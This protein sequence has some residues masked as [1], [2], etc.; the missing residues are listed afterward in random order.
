MTGEPEKKFAAGMIRA[1][2]W[3]NTAKNGNEFKSVSVTKSYQKD[4]EWKNR[5]CKRRKL[6]LWAGLRKN[7]LFEF[8]YL[9]SE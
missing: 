4:G 6:T 1:T 2:V 5:C 9:F 8:F 7:R 3:K